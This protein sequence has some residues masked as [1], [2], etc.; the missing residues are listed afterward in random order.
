MANP[1]PTITFTLNLANPESSSLPYSDILKGNQTVTEATAQVDSR[2]S[3]LST[4]TGASTEGGEGSGQGS[5]GN[6]AQ[7]NGS[8]IV[9][10]GLNALYIKRTYAATGTSSDLMTVVSEV[11]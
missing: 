7:K 2:S 8:T 9:A 4:L 10:Y 1:K 11:W 6:I 5:G 3:W